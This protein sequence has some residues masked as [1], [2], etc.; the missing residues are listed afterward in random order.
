MFKFLNALVIVLG[1]GAALGVQVQG[2]AP[3]PAPDIWKGVYTIAQAENGETSYVAMCS[4]CHNPDLSGGQ[5]GAQT[6]PALGGEKFKSRW[7]LNNVDRLFHTIRETMPRGTPGI[8]T[9]DAALGLVAY[10]LKFN[11]FPAGDVPLAAT[12]PLASLVFVPQDGVVAKREIVNFAQIE[13]AGCVTE[14]PN[15]SWML[16]RA[17][18]PVAARAGAFG[19]GAGNVQ[20]GSQTYRLVSVG[21]FRSELRPGYAVQIKGLIRKDPDMT[22]INLTAI[23]PTGSPCRN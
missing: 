4:R 17:T 3:A 19:A 9:D 16:T 10:I 13:T 5:I 12:V 23:A 20:L 14:G 8:L 2:Q 21:A 22:L 15:Q 1:L 7:E 6:A 18:E 11:G